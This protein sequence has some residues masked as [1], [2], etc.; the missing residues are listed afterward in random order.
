MYL[1][2]N[3]LMQ[4]ADFAIAADM[5]NHTH[6]VACQR[7]T[8]MQT[9]LNLDCGGKKFHLARW[10]SHLRNCTLSIE[11]IGYCSWY[12]LTTEQLFSSKACLLQR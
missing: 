3:A 6:C 2:R 10:Y 9:A 8:S 4:C 11:A 12:R 7:I 5:A 1:D